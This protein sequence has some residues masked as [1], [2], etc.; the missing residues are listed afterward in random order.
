[1]RVF[2]IHPEKSVFKPTQEIEFLGFLL[3]SVNITIRLPPKASYVK[4]AYMQLL[5]NLRP[6]IRD[7]AHVIELT[8]S[9][10][11]GVQFGDL[12]Y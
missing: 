1:M 2:V 12:H 4:T 9:S 11:P 5:A 10:L 7:L 8:F 3:N 6:S